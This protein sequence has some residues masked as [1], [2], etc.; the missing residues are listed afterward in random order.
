MISRKTI[1]TMLVSAVAVLAGAQSA[2]AL[3]GHVPPP[4]KEKCY[5]VVKAGA[6]DCASASAS[7]TCAGY[8]TVNRSGE[9]WVAVP[10]GLC[11]KLAG[12]SLTPIAAAAPT[13]APA[14]TQEAPPQGEAQQPPAPLA[15]PAAGPAAQ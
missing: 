7:H 14:I 6:N 1:N 13:R 9:E 8:A 2:S 12:G 5:G 15:P 10:K 3:E 11:D 4:E